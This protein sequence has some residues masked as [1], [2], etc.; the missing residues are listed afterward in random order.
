ME[1]LVIVRQRNYWGSG[2]TLA[3]AKTNYRKASGRPSTNTASVVSYQGA[4][5]E[6]EKI[7]INDIDG[8][9]MYPKTLTQVILQ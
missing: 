2:K 4:P 7:T 1:I 6:I 3:E 5:K 9:I 8:G